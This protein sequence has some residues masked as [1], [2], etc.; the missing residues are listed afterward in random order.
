MA[1]AYRLD[2]T[3]NFKAV[4]SDAELQELRAHPEF[5]ALAILVVD[6]QTK[7]SRLEIAR[8]HYTRL[9]RIWNRAREAALDRSSLQEKA[10]LHLEQKKKEED[11][12]KANLRIRAVAL[13]MGFEPIEV[14]PEPPDPKVEARIAELNEAYRAAQNAMKAATQAESDA[15]DAASTL[16]FEAARNEADRVLRETLKNSPLNGLIKLEVD[17]W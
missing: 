3:P 9:W 1:S 14:P 4:C 16:E 10:N 11:R 13:L 12:K 6:C 8:A 17:H 5:L 2:F 15:L 7:H